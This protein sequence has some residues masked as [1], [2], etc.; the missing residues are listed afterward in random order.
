MDHVTVDPTVA[1]APPGAPAATLH[2]LELLSAGR[3]LDDLSARLARAPHVDCRRPRRRRVRPRGPWSAATRPCTRRAEHLLG[4][5][6]K[7]LRPMCVALAARMGL[8]LQRA[9]RDL[10]VAAS[11]CTTPRSCTTTWWTSATSA[12]APPP[13][14]CS[15]ATPRAIFAGDWL[16]VEAIRPASAPRASRAT[17]STA[18][19][20]CSRRCSTPRGCSSRCAAASTPPSTPRSVVE[21]KTASLFRW[22]LYAGAPRGRARPGVQCDALERYGAVARRGVPARRR[23]A[24]RVGRRTHHGQGALHRPAR[25]QAHAPAAPRGPARPAFCG[26]R[27]GL[28]R[29]TCAGAVHDDLAQA[30]RVRPCATPAPSKT[31]VASRV[32]SPTRPSHTSTYCPMVGPALPRERRRVAMLHRTK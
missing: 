1:V 29:E 23:R 15:T 26:A 18:P 30:A 28:A 6:G 27:G 12:A 22:A 4:L 11:S 3:D 24:R 32:A 10:A 2:H 14:G 9:A 16:L 13:R 7:R 8:G 5:G 21:G 19:S 25:G 20:T 17:C 31:A